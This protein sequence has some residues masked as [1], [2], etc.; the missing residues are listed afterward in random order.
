MDLMAQ[1][2]EGEHAVEEHEDA[3]GDVEVVLGVVSD[4]FEAAHD[5]IGAIA[6]RSGGERRKAFHVRGAM[7][8]QE[9]LDDVEDVSGAGDRLCGRG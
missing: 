1:V 6:D 9:S 3:V 8:L 2:I 4:V 5:V 7:L